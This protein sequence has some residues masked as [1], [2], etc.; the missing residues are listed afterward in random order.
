MGHTV[1]YVCKH[2]EPSKGTCDGHI[3]KKLMC[4]RRTG[5]INKEH[6]GR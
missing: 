1:S 3:T 5:Q 2:K 6:T 4:L